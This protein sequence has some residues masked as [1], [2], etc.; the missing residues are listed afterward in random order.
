MINRKYVTLKNG[1]KLVFINDNTKHIQYA[2]IKIRYGGRT[3]KVKVN[4]ELIVIPDGVAHLLEHTV[5]ENTIYGNLNN[6]FKDNYIDSNAFTSYDDTCYYIETVFD[7]KEHLIE[8]IKAVNTP[9]FTDEQI[10][11]IKLPIYEEIKS[12]KDKKYKKFADAKIHNALLDN[13]FIDNVGTKE[14]IENINKDYLMNIY[15]IFY[16]PSNQIIT[17]SGNYDIKEITKVIEDTY[18]E[19]NKESIPFEVIKDDNS[20]S[21][22]KD[23]VNIVD[24]KYNEVYNIAFKIDASKF[25]L[26]D[27]RKIKYYLNY[28]L[29]SHFDDNSDA[30]K[31]VLDKGYSKYSFGR[32][33]SFD[34]IDNVIM[35]DIDLETTNIKEVKKIILDTLNKKDID[36]NNFKLRHKAVVIDRIMRLDNIYKVLSEY[37]YNIARYDFDGI[38][39]VEFVDELNPKECL[40]YINKLDFSHYC[41]LIQTKE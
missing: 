36:E 6:F 30:F 32:N 39:T 8:L 22:R 37:S 17:I 28:Y 16:Q 18:N 10:E 24:P 3:K 20:I 25:Q 4:N 9:V 41:E 14:S 15:N 40:E 5:Y 35:M 2:E 34:F 33:V 19:L 21:F 11:H 23:I 1:L 29:S 27:I 13:D 7:F 31:E 12:V 38:D 26:E